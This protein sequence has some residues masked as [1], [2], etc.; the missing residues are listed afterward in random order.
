MELLIRLIWVIN[1]KWVFFLVELCA[2]TPFV[3]VVLA[4][5]HFLGIF[6]QVK[7][8]ASTPFIE[9]V[10]AIRDLLGCC[11]LGETSYCIGYKD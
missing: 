8:G 2:L 6:F 11:I 4:I 9:V 5:R 3:D 1:S 10:L 7:L